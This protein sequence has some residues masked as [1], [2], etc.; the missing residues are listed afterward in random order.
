MPE[1]L[2]IG[3]VSDYFLKV[4]KSERIRSFSRYEWVSGVKM[5]T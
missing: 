5:D 4:C 3:F 2:S 1:A